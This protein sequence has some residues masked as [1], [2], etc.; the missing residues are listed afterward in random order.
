MLC[1]A[2][3]S[4]EERKTYR[5][6]CRKQGIEQ[7]E[8]MDREKYTYI[9]SVYGDVLSHDGDSCPDTDESDEDSDSVDSEEE[10]DA[11]TSNLPRDGITTTQGPATQFT[12]QTL[13][14]NHSHRMAVEEAIAHD[15]TKENEERHRT[16]VS[17]EARH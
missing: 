14:Q 8:D 13:R 4:R 11:S 15:L 9:Q 10:A 2:R 5:N 7:E 6:L 12:S 17:A 16:F 3:S 1:E